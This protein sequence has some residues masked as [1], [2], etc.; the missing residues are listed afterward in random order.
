MF[1]IF[2]R[3]VFRFCAKQTSVLVFIVVPRFPSFGTWFSVFVKNANE[4]S[5]L[6]SEVV[7]AFPIWVPIPL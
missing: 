2:L 4:F 5:D 7:L 6:E 1:V 3:S